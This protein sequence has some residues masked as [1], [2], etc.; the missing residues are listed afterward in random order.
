MQECQ[1]LFLLAMAFACCA[2]AARD[3]LQKLH[4]TAEKCCKATG[5]LSYHAPD[6]LLTEPLSQGTFSGYV[7]KQGSTKST[8]MYSDCQTR[9]PYTFP[10]LAIDAPQA[11]TVDV[12]IKFT[13]VETL[14]VS[15]CVYSSR[16]KEEGHWGRV[17]SASW[18][19]RAKRLRCSEDTILR[20][21]QQS[22]DCKKTKDGC[23]LGRL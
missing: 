22:R 7:C 10:G 20:P 11:E 4:V 19:K 3:E 17:V 15:S 1:L 5:K 14:D 21:E 13:T 12:T 18:Q 23:N 8:S 9:K 6:Q 16:C 2:M